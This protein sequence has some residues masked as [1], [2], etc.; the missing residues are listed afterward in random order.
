MARF[1]PHTSRRQ[2]QAPGP[3]C[4]WLEE[5]RPNIMSPTTQENGL[6]VAADRPW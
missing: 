2:A 6:V 4:L 3:C 1:P 5:H